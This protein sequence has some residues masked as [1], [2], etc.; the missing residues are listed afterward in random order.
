MG[1]RLG[2][3]S[4]SIRDLSSNLWGLPPATTEL[5]AVSLLRPDRFDGGTLLL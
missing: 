4:S 1:S 2:E 3:E 5:V